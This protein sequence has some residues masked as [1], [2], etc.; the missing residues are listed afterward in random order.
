MNDTWDRQT[1]LNKAA[2]FCAYQER[3]AHEVRQK[4]ASR[5]QSTEVIES[6]V[7]ELTRDGF[8]NEERFLESFIRGKFFQKKWGRI[9]ITYALRIH[10][11][12]AQTIRQAMDALIPEEKYRAAAAELMDQK[13]SRMHK[14]PPLACKG[15]V[16]QFLAGKGFEQDVI[17]DVWNER[18]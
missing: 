2:R 9:K 8:I 4:L 10:E 14:Q 17:Y 11:I 1:A 12:D 5:I 6:I 7:E 15:K 13:L 3:S 18:G 16:F